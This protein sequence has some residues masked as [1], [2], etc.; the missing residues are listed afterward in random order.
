MRLGAASPRDLLDVTRG[1][2]AEGLFLAPSWAIVT[3][4]QDARATARALATET[5]YVEA[6]RLLDDA[7]EVFVH[8]YM[9]ELDVS[10]GLDRSPW[11]KLLA[12]PRVILGCLCPAKERARCH[13]TPLTKV[14][15][16]LG[17]DPRGEFGEQLSLL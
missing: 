2:A 8:A 12:R 7:F 4:M 1:S 16:A 3:P 10:Y 11:T 17:A 5:H 6:E 14:L 9:E 13:L 15:V